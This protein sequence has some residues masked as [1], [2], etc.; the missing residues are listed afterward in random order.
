MSQ[1]CAKDHSGRC[2]WEVDVGELGPAF[3]HTQRGILGSIDVMKDVRG[4]Q[5][6]VPASCV[7]CRREV[8]VVQGLQRDL[9][10]CQLH[11][12]DGV[13]LGRYLVRVSG[14]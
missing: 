6:L 1:D 2:R 9:L 12:C 10:W 14:M 7:K 5:G 13:P 3:T 8:L 11:S 4:S